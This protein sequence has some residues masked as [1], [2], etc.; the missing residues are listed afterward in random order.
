MSN[1]RTM[2]LPLLTQ[3]PT[4]TA[5][6]AGASLLGGSLGDLL[7]GST[8]GVAGA[9]LGALVI[10]LV[11]CLRALVALKKQN[12][13]GAIAIDQERDQIVERMNGLH[14][15]EIEVLNRQNARDTKFLQDQIT[16]HEKVEL[17]TRRRMHAILAEQQR[18]IL[19]LRQLEAVC[20]DKQITI[21]PFSAKTFE[22]VAALYP[23]P[24]NPPGSTA[25]V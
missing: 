15:Q 1:S 20:S 19:A 3:L 7:A 18:T 8:G 11:A 14:R 22:D 21:Q 2:A 13:D 24:E 6:V 4:S 16:W 12:T 23:L 17:V 25:A 9:V 5:Y 10:L